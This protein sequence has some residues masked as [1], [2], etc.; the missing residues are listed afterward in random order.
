MYSN[1][2]GIIDKLVE[3]LYDIYNTYIYIYT[4]TL[5]IGVPSAQAEAELH[6]L[7]PKNRSKGRIF[8]KGWV[9]DDRPQWFT[10]SWAPMVDGYRAPL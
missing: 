8:S 5:K 3:S 4:Y 7:G 9:V 6:L 2:V 1:N 10:T